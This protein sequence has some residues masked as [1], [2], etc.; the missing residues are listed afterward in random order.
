MFL[1]LIAQSYGGAYGDTD[2]SDVWKWFLPTIMPTLSL[3]VGVFVVD[4][5]IGQVG[6]GKRRQSTE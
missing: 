6:E 2:V 5:G 1:L 4:N 3:M